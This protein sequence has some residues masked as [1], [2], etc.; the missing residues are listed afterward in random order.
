MKV[1]TCLVSS[2]ML[3][4]ADAYS[5]KIQKTAFTYISRDSVIT[6]ASTRYVANSFLRTFFMGNNYRK[7]WSQPVS[8]PVFRLSETKFKIEELGGGMQTKSLHLLDEKGKEWSL[9]SI[10]KYVSGALPEFLHN[11]GVE[12]VT[13]DLISASLPYGSPVAG[14]L[15]QAVGVNAAQPTVYFVAADPALKQYSR[16]FANTVCLLEERDPNFEKTDKSVEV[17][18]DLQKDNDNK[19]HQPVLLR[20]RLMDMIFAD[21]DR[22]ADNWRWGKKDSAGFTFYYAIP[23]D[24]DWVFYYSKGLV[25]T[26]ARYIALPHL[27]NF[28]AEAKNLKQLS[29]KEWVFDK[30]FLNELTA[31][32]WEKAISHI[33]QNLTDEKIE[34][35]VNKL[36]P[37]V[38]DLIGAEMIN[39]LKGRVKTFRK[40]A[41]KY[42]RFISGD[43]WINGSD[44]DEHFYIE[45]AGE[46][47][48]LTVF[49]IKGGAKGMVVYERV[50]RYPET[51]SLLVKGLGGDDIFEVAENTSSKIRLALHGGEDD[52]VYRV[53]GKIKTKVFDKASEQ[54]TF[55]GQAK[56]RIKYIDEHI[57]LDPTE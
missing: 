16:I 21:W 41:M 35:A 4:A 27:I 55:A 52:D 8:L 57:K 17:L 14:A 26:L 44:K 12:Q 51:Y 5:Q 48:K 7:V 50:F 15:N 38:F 22:H 1:W 23:R 24:R 10:D 25:P 13:Q 20:A 37:N 36:P 3:V 53:N 2:M 32:E 6:K 29:Y 49:D 28:T 56:Y 19:I 43:V 18:E 33:Q 31:P 11:T 46:N 34:D 54:N 30:T 42:Y 39:K 47:L 40:E 45:N 9:R